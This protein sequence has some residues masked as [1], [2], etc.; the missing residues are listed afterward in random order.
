M[1][2][3]Y[4]LQERVEELTIQISDVQKQSTQMTE[5]MLDDGYRPIFDVPFEERTG[6]LQY[7]R[8]QSPNTRARRRQV[9]AGR[10]VTVTETRLT[11]TADELLDELSRVLVDLTRDYNR[12]IMLGRR[13][14]GALPL[15][16]SVGTLEKHLYRAE[17]LYDD[18]AYR[19]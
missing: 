15:G 2:N 16:M 18:Y 3:I 11:I 17:A 14:P 9:G 1:E 7:D 12:A 4:Y 6:R 19:R 13:F 10:G 8:N 5:R